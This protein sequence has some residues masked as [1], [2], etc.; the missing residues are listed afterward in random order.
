MSTSIQH[1]HNAYSAAAPDRP[2]SERTEDSSSPYIQRI[3]VKK[4]RRILLLWTEDID[5]IEAAGNY[6]RLVSQ[7]Q[8]HLYRTTMRSLE[9]KLDPD[10]FLRIHRSTIV[11]V[12]RIREVLTTPSGDYVAI[13]ADGTRTNWSRGY[14]RQLNEFLSRQT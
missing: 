7:G 9:K 10:R 3:A 14:R 12:D 1:L 13:L 2:R 6:V 5:M 4:A 8:G 11:N